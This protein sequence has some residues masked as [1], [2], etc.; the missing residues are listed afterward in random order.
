MNINLQPKVQKGPKV[1][2]MVFVKKYMR[3]NGSNSYKEKTILFQ[4][5][6]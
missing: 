2:Y 3:L 1:L 5:V 4:A 6:E